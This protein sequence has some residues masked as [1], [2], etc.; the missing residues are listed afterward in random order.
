L[1]E[2]TSF[3]KTIRI[4]DAEITFSKIEDSNFCNHRWWHLYS[5]DLSQ[6]F[7]IEEENI[8]KENVKKVKN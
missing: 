7:L 5:G 4:E 1:V 8:K 3:P 6:P 2:Q